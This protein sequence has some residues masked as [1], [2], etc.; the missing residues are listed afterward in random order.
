MNPATRAI[1]AHNA[2]RDPERL[3]RKLALIAGDPFAFMRGTCHLFYDGLGQLAARP[4]LR[5][6]PRVW[7][8]GDL[9]LENVGTFKGDNRLVYFD[10]NDFDETCLAPFTLD[11]VRLSASIKVAAA[12]LKIGAAQGDALSAQFLAIY[13]REVAVGKARWMERSTSAGMVKELLK[14]LKLRSRVELLGRRTVMAGKRRRLRLSGSKALPVTSAQRRRAEA[15]LADYAARREHTEFFEPLDVAR[16][17]AGNGALGLERY[18]V[19]VRGRGGVDGNFLMD[20]KHAAPSS[21]KPRLTGAQPK[22]ESEAQRVVTIQNIVQAASPALLGTATQGGE[23][24]LVKELQPTADRLNLPL[25]N[26]RIKRLE[27]VIVAMAQVTAWG[28]LRGCGRLGAATV[29][30]LAAYAA[31]PHWQPEL[32]ALARE[33]GAMVTEQW[34]AYAKDFRDGVVKV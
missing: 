17:V 21:L 29:E 30:E 19:L 1:L 4:L 22:W 9:H 16:R 8:C 26:G 2:G 18:I 27:Q 33:A 5:T 12:G 7:I 20:L 10:L 6:A 3:Q 24:Y 25:W 11:L 23:S 31:A 13:A 28:H 15:L 32:G 34:H 14:N